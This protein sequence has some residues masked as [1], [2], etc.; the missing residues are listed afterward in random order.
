MHPALI[1]LLSFLA[2]SAITVLI[3]RSVSPWNK[4]RKPYVGRKNKEKKG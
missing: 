2:G 3:A 4:S 1:V